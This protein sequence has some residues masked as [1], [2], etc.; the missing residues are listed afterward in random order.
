MARDI[1]IYR[2]VP[3]I[4][5]YA[6][7]SPNLESNKTNTDLDAAASAIDANM[8]ATADSGIAYLV[9]GSGRVTKHGAVK[10]RD[11]MLRL[12][13]IEPSEWYRDQSGNSIDP[14]ETIR[15]A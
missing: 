7:T 5:G 3:I 14:M 8:N 12:P 4:N 9:K 11:T 6:Q 15:Q 1:L 13:G 10:G 2:D